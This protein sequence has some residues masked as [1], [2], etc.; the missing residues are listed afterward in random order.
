MGSRRDQDE[1][2]LHLRFNFRGKL[3]LKGGHAYADF[4]AGR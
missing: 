1:V 4:S 2:K 3:N